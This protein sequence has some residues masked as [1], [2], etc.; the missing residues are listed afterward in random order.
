M[1]PAEDSDDEENPFVGPYR[2]FPG[3][4]SVCR[5]F[6]DCEAKLAHLG[7][8]RGVVTCDPEVTHE[9]DGVNYLDYVLIG[10]DGIFDKLKN[11]QINQI[12]WD[13][14]T[15]ARQQAHTQGQPASIHSIAG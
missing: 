8:V 2:V 7:G 9:Q 3:R 1:P 4:L 14:T 12:V 15:K 10:S 5:T 6:G 11:D 13:V